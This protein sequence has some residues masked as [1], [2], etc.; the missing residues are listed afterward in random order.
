[1]AGPLLLEHRGLV[2]KVVLHRRLA[3]LIGMNVRLMLQRSRCYARHGVGLVGAALKHSLVPLA[4]LGRVLPERGLLLDLG[5]GEGMLGNLI[6]ASCPGLLIRGVDRDA[7]K[8]ALANRASLPNAHFEA[9][10]ILECSFHGAAAAI[11]NDVLHHHP[12]P[13][14]VDLLKK[15]AEFLDGAGVLI[16]KEVDALDRLDQWW[17]SFWDRRRYP[18]DTLHFRDNQ[19]WR[20]ALFDSGFQVLRVHR[21]RHPWPASRMVFVCRRRKPSIGARR[22]SP[23]GPASPDS[24]RVLITGGTGFIGSHLAKYLCEKGLGGRAADVTIL[25]RDRTRMTADLDGCCRL[26]VGDIECLPSM[27]EVVGEMEYVFHLAAHKD[28][29]GGKTVFV[30]NMKGTQALLRALEGSTKLKRL[31][32][33]SSMGAVDRAP[34][35]DCSSPIEEGSPPHATSPY[36]LA[37]YESER[38]IAQ[39]SLPFSVLRLP[40]CYGPRMTPRTHVRALTEAV[41]RGAIATRF[42]WPGRVSLL[43]VSECAKAFIFV[44]SDPRTLGQT[45]FVSDGEPIR[46][47]SLLREM[48]RTVGC[49]AARLPVPALAVWVARRLR[50]VLP[51]TVRCL[52]LDVLCVDDRK[53]RGLGFLAPSRGDNFLLPL[54]RFMNDGANPSLHRSK[55]LVT[56]AASGI[57]YAL[58]VQLAARGRGVIMVDRDP[59]IVDIAAG[60]PEAEACLADLSEEKGLAEVRSRAEAGYVNWVVNCAGVGVRGDVG[61]SDPCALSTLVAVNIQALTQISESAIRNFRCAREG[62]LVNIASS[63]GFQPLPG[64]AIYAAS[65]AYVLSFSEALGEEQSHSGI[66]VLTVC[67]SGVA[68][69]FQARAGVRSA[70]GERLLSPED[71]AA[72][73]LRAARCRRSGTVFIGARATQMSLLARVLPRSINVRL[74]KRLMDA[75]R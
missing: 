67:P 18:A 55:A 51:F 74:W 15:A 21:V 1:M 4:L 43:E 50:R 46:L 54:V 61:A 75:R 28:F 9:G 16:V 25:A 17:T 29:F 19:E 10:D 40:W 33:A 72:A 56:G 58:S 35:D 47:G 14:Q 39:S 11:F 37:K 53:L 24:V 45:F 2:Q 59:R 36:G 65:K 3:S 52:F 13:M 30:N 8:V 60:V 71:V 23:E 69:C 63:A 62:V 73:V 48:G 66:V 26:L 5:C 70:P 44:A 27:R 32:F 22:S 6:A 41:M 7:D 12:Y 34:G 68:T 64:M 42:D 49:K 20:G 38:L 31:V 57:G